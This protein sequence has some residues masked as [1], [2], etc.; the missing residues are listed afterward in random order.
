MQN[1]MSLREGT[2]LNILSTDTNMFAFFDQTA[3]SK[4]FSSRPI[5][6]LAFFNCL[7]TVRQNTLKIFVDG[8]T[9]GRTSNH[10]SDML[11]CYFINGSGEMR[12]NFCGQFFG[13]FET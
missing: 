9:F 2:T 10:T 11:K 4:G 1:G 6:V 7:F 8:E 5:N 3:E 13:R 12:Q